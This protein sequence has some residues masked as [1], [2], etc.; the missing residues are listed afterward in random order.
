MRTPAKDVT[1]YSAEQLR[2]FRDQFAPLANDYRQCGRK[3]SWYVGAAVLLGVLGLLVRPYS[4][5]VFLVVWL[6]TV[7]LLI[8]LVRVGLPLPKCPA[9]NAGLDSCGGEFCPECGGRSLSKQV[10]YRYRRCGACRAKLSRGKGGRYFRIC[11]CN[12]CGV[13][14]DERGL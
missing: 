9:C 4:A 3:A 6:G 14:L 12:R 2:A 13:M 1:A 5:L 11:A 10:W 8:Q 7:V